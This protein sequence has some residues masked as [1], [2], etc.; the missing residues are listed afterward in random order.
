MP[1]QAVIP[2]TPGEHEVTVRMD[3]RW[4]NVNGQ[5]VTDDP[6]GFAQARA[7]AATLGIAFGSLSR[8]SHGVLA[9]GRASFTLLGL[10]VR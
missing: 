4:T 8:R 6:Q 1:D 10:E 5:P 3:A 9:D 7:E 2:L